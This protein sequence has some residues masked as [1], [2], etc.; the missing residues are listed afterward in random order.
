MSDFSR[1]I[2]S[3]A[4][5]RAYNKFQSGQ[6]MGNIFVENPTDI[7]FWQHVVNAVDGSR[8]KVRPISKE[9]AAGKRTLQKR[10]AA[11]NQEFLVAVDSD[12]DFLCPDRHAEAQQM[13]NNPFVLHT[14]CY[15]RE[16]FQCCHHSLGAITE[17]LFFHQQF[18]S[19]IHE[20]LIQYSY[21]VYPALCVFSYLHNK[22]WQQYSEGE[23]NL[24]VRFNSGV[25]LI[26]DELQVNDDAIIQLQT[27]VEAYSLS[28]YAAIT[29]DADFDSFKTIL[30]TRGITE[31][32]AYMF[33]NGHCLQ[34]IVV[35][36]MLEKIA[37]VTRRS[38]KDSVAQMY[39]EPERLKTK[40]Q[41]LNE[42]DNYYKNERQLSTL[43]S[44]GQAFVQDAFFSLITA[45]LD[46]II[47]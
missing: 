30:T 17:I 35:K 8:Y 14:Y 5:I 37:A 20:A 44:N 19:Q 2:G 12:Y 46:A 11:L 23:F 41:K 15:S 25:C 26:N 39:P 29:D 22:N 1:M 16:S 28:L 42:I 43:L 4:F 27:Q 45:K 31:D 40:R 24:A 7:P 38:E 9:Q 32:N 47:H 10:Y 36:P 34:D 21:A 13:N 3:P 33:I 6:V 18:P